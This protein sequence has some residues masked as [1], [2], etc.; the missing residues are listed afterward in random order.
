MNSFAAS[1][2]L[3]GAAG[4]QVFA[5]G[6]DRALLEREVLPVYLTRC[7]WFGGKAREL[8]GCRIRELVSVES[9]RLAV[10]ETS[11]ARGAAETYLLP[12]QVADGAQAEALERDAPA[13]V[14]ARFRGGGVLFDAVQDADF[15]A[16]LFGLIAHGGV[17]G[18]L[19]GVAG[20][21][22]PEHAPPSRVL[23]VEQ[24]NTAIIY[25]DRVFLKLY[26]RLEDGVNPDAEILRFLGAREFPQVPP[27]HGVL[28]FRGAGRAP[29]VLAL[30][31][32]M[33]ANEGDAWSFTLRELTRQLECVLAG[34]ASEAE[35]IETAYLARA[36]QLG[37]RTGALH[38]ALA[39]DVTDAN[40]A[41]VPLTAGDFSELAET[42]RATAEEV[43]AGIAARFDTL[44]SATRALASALLAAEPALRSRI[45]ALGT[46]PVAAA[47][48]RTHG[49]Y[50]LGQVLNTGDDFVIIDFEGE[51]AR[52]LAERRRKRSP[53]R[54]VAGMLRSFYYAA[55]SA[56]ENFPERRAE[57]EAPVE[58]WHECV[59][60]AFLAAWSAATTGAIFVP[61][62]RADRTRLL[63]AFLL[64]KALYEV[65][66]ELNNRPAWLGIPLRGIAQILRGAA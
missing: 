65:A 54:D 17:V 35:W 37:K 13:A 26:R 63:D 3:P 49:D 66:Y 32:G 21:G 11:Y 23:A 33:V 44:D 53:L 25:G 52:P 59:C 64:E 36:A 31:T 20:D 46:Q 29:Q 57:L 7:R 61:V 14:V 45:A 39:S 55:H 15:R 43:L 41:P 8:R 38:G 1:F 47:K 48:T 5:D 2:F 60:A 62:E 27:F 9:A 34:D 30:A 50:H 16:A 22:L 19:A 42:V 24:S 56:L 10:V 40:F 28:E 12:L 18:G 58:R 4:P 6:E 51:P